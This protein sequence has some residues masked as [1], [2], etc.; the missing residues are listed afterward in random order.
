[1]GGE[2]TATEYNVA[3]LV[4]KITQPDGSFI[5][6]TYDAAHRLTQVQDNLGNKTLY[7]LDLQGNR[8]LEEVKDPAN[9]VTRR[10][11]RSYNNLN[12]LQSVTGALQ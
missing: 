8:T 3:G 7:T 9:V 12:R 10:V 11:T 4:T 2:I 6:Y 5:T 1:M